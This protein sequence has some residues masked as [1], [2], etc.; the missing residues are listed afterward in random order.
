MGPERLKV[1]LC[2]DEASSAEAFQAALPEHDVVYCPEDKV[3]ENVADVDVIIPGRGQ[4][5]AK[6]IAVAKRCRLI[7]Q[8]GVGID[9]VDLAAASAR[10]IPVANVPSLGSGN[11]ESVAE[12]A[13][14]LMIGVARNYPAL[15]EAIRTQSWDESPF[16]ETIGNSVVGIVGVG[17]VGGLLARLLQPFGCRIIGVKRRR[18]EQLRRRLGLD[19]L[20]TME[21]LDELMAQVDFLVLTLALTDETRGIIGEAELA[22]MKRGSYLVNVSRGAIVDYQ[23]LLNA[24]ETAHLAGVGLDVFWDEPVDPADPIFQY[25]VVATPH[26]AGATELMLRGNTDIIAENVRRLVDGR[27]ILNRLN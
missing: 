23:A 14:F 20:G 5:D 17:S 9:M 26:F 21:E 6:A 3:I 22:R 25:P 7:Q 18:D 11:A 16:G 15:Q 1:I 13:V 4:I 10:G 27:P 12:F 8:F 19:W 2:T 24:L